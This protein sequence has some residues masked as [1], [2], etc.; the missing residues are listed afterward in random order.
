MAEIIAEG[1]KNPEKADIV[2][3]DKELEEMFSAG[4]QFGYSRSRR[5]PKMAGFV[6]GIKNNVEVFDLEKT[7]EALRAA[8]NLLRNI[9]RARKNVLWVGTKSSARVLVEKIAKEFSHSYVS[10]RW[11]GG[12]LTNSKLIRERI[13]YL[14][15]LKRKRE[16]GEWDK[17]T[18]KEKLQIS[19]EIK[20]LDE[21]FSGI[22]NLKND[23]EVVVIVDPKEEKTAFSEARRV[24]LPI[25]AVLSSD[26]DPLEIT[27][28]IPANDSAYSSLEYILGR[29]SRAWKEGA[30]EGE[31]VKNNA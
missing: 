1:E 13:K 17:Y 22:E 21:K 15:E 12:T 14:E 31:Q 9:G 4:L 28:P 30:L 29:L 23:L 5:H 27:Y 26:N 24:S 25:V 10:G 7:R 19:R 8:E 11:V 6:Y 3:V 18:K 16:T 20:A 2:K